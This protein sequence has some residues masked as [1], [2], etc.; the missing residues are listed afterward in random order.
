MQ[1]GIDIIEIERIKRSY[2]KYGEKF[3]IKILTQ[4]EIAYCFTKHHPFESI[5]ARFAAKEAISKA[6]GS[7]ISKEFAW[8]SVEIFNDEKGKPTV[9]WL[10]N[11]HKLEM[12]IKLSISHTHQYAVAVALIELPT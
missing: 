2:E 7:G 12:A 9:K 8:H 5:A 10:E 4:N 11:K 3:L 1:I 6:I